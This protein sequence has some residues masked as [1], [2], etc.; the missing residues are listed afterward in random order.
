MAWIPVWVLVAVGL[1]LL[2]AVLLALRARWARTARA[3][4]RY[5]MR[6]HD[7]TNALRIGLVT[8]RSRRAS[9]R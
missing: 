9:D 8:L 2:V 4:A 6:W 3:A 1:V 5:R 7:G